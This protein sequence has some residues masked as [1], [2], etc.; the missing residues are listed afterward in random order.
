MASL[1][2]KQR[3][4][5]EAAD[6]PHTLGNGYLFGAPVG[7]LGWFASL[8]IGF[9]SGFAAFFLATFL[10]IFGLLIANGSGHK[11]DYAISYKYIGLPVGVL[12]AV[13]ALGY[14]GML[15]AR[16]ISRKA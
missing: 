8:L 7:D 11:A 10:G 13:V 14:L 2:H 1:T 15:W 16:R 9:A 5:N 4:L 3:N 12:V 6:V